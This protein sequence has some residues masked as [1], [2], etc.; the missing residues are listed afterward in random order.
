MYLFYI[1]ETGTRDP[2]VVKI[3]PDGTRKDKDPLYVLTAVGLYEFKWRRFE[4]MIT[5]LKLELIDSLAKAKAGQ[6][7][8]DQAEVKSSWLRQPTLRAKESAFLSA[9][10]EAELR[11]VSEVYF[12]ALHDLNMTVMAIVIDKRHLQPHMDH[13]K[14]HLK[15]YELWGWAAERKKKN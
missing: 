2:E 14:L 3:L 15:A 11:R 12:D 6:F 8:L 1:D 4:A 13:L 10:S 5:R 9:L 7:T